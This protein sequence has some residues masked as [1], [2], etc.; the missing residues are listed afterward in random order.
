MSYHRPGSTAAAG[1]AVTVRSARTSS[2]ARLSPSANSGAPRGGHSARKRTSP[3]GPS[4]ACGRIELQAH[5]DAGPIA[6]AIEAAQRFGGLVAADRQGARRIRPQPGARRRLRLDD[7]RRRD[8]PAAETRRRH[9]FDAMLSEQAL[10][11]FERRAAGRFEVGDEHQ[12]LAAIPIDARL[13]VLQAPPHEVVIFQRCAAAVIGEIRE[14]VLRPVLRD[15]VAGV[16]VAEAA[17]VLAGS[18]RLGREAQDRP[19]LRAEILAVRLD[20]RGRQQQDHERDARAPRS[21]DRHRRR[22]RAGQRIGAN[23]DD[24]IHER[25]RRN[26]AVAVRHRERARHQRHY[27]SRQEKEARWGTDAAQHDERPEREQDTCQRLQQRLVDEEIVAVAAVVE[28]ACGRHD[29]RQRARLLGRVLFGEMG[30]P[31]LELLEVGGRVAEHRRADHDEGRGGDQPA[32]QSPPPGARLATDEHGDQHRDHRW[33]DSA[34]IV[35]VDRQRRP[36]TGQYPV[37]PRTALQRTPQPEQRQHLERRHHDHA[38]ADPAE[39]PCQPDTARKPSPISATREP[40]RAA[41]EQVEHRQRR[42]RDDGRGQ[43][44]RFR[45]IAEPRH[46]RRAEVHE[47]RFASPRRRDVRRVRRALQDVQRE[48]AVE[49]G[50]VVHAARHRGEVHDAKR[51]AEQAQRAYRKPFA[52]RRP[53][54]RGLLTPSAPSDQQPPGEQRDDRR[55]RLPAAGA[56]RRRKLPQPLPAPRRREYHQQRER[57]RNPPSPTHAAR[58]GTEDRRRRKAGAPGTAGG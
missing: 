43:L 28:Q 36:G 53:R 18:G 14:R 27:Q 39:H 47:E 29:A 4:P 8:L 12:S 49:G 7:Q 48:H 22:Q 16:S 52:A 37:A 6:D 17:Q 46:Q 54:R 15:D 2:P 56:A 30:R 19:A 55:E 33:H 58:D 42:D 44:D 24:H 9:R 57:H 10:Q 34:G 1:T 41:G 38:P 40:T 21:I 26:A 32:H 31:R 5:G 13:D 23:G 3:A 51:D 11:S 25:Q 35:R 20:R 45:H 50:I